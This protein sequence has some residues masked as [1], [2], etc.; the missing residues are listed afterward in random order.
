MPRDI[1][2]QCLSCSIGLLLSVRVLYSLG[3]FIYPQTIS[4]STHMH[5]TI[6][7][8]RPVES[9]Q[10]SSGTQPIAGSRV[11]QATNGR[12][13]YMINIIS[14]IISGLIIGVLARFFYPGPV[15]MGGFATILLGIGGSLLAG[16]IATRGK[17][18]FQQ[19]GCLA[20]VL[21]AILLIFIGRMLGWG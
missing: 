12:H 13:I 7:F 15:P 17:A 2:S 14:A 11:Q 1:F 9:V 8:A 10:K 20:S 16:A 18:G 5:T 6:A 21:G 4:G 19:A 3:E